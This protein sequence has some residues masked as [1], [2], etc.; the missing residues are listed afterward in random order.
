MKI[1]FNSSTG[2]SLYVAKRVQENFEECELISIPKAIN[3]DK[4]DYNDDVI[5]FVYPIHYAGLP[6]VVHQFL[7]KINIKKDTY[8]F[9]I[10]VSGGGGANTSFNQID[11]LLKDKCNVSNYCTIKYISNYLRAGREPSSERA[12]KSIEKNED[13]LNSFIKSIERHE[14]TTRKYRFGIGNI[15]YNIAV[16]ML[17]KLDKNFNVNDDC[18]NC[19]MCQKICPVQN[20][21]ME[22]NKPKWC[23]KCVDCMACINIC[24]KKAI[25]IG[26]KTVNKNRY[27]NPY[28]KREELL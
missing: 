19:K 21:V 12:I 8:V 28:I 17:K 10:G 11:T 23:T 22:N 18:I 27:I 6:R 5:G 25:N 7:S 26:N 3:Q 24:P 4:Y 13:I 9:A 14:V 20:I 15:E 2:N 16:S 1:F